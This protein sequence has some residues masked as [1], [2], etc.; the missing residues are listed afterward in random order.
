[1]NRRFQGSVV[2][3]EEVLEMESLCTEA[4]VE[5][6]EDIE[7][8]LIRIPMVKMRWMNVAMHENKKSGYFIMVMLFLF[9]KSE[10][11]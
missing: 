7:W 5:E 8:G 4:M 3:E 9:R 1:M 11:F 10:F 6:G 2:G